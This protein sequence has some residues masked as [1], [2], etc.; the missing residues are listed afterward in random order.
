MSLRRLVPL[1]ALALSA[2]AQHRLHAVGIT[3]KNWVVGYPLLPSG[4]F[5]KSSSGEW[6]NEGHRHPYITGVASLPGDPGAIYL[7]AGNGCI[8]VDP[9]KPGWRILTGADVTELRAISVGAGGTVAFGHTTGIR[10]SRDLGRTWTEIAARLPRRYM[11]ALL[12]DRV[13]PGHFLAG[14]ENGLYLTTDEGRTW[15]LAGAAGFQIMHIA[16]SPHNPGLILAATQQGGLFRSADGG[17][18]F[19]NPGQAGVNRNLYD[20]AFDPTAPARIATCGWGVGVVVS[21]DGG[22]TWQPRNAGLPSYDVWSCIFDPDHPGRLYAGVHEEHLYVSNDAGR[23]WSP[24]GLP[25]SIIYRMAFLPA[26]GAR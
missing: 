26:R 4:L 6:R 1:L 3:T 9:V 17:R 10:I 13:R 20:I 19:E 2:S 22:T 23:T 12:A 15:T 14:A 8:R 21:E 16:Q 7:A 11:N 5:V 24:D 18:T 25:G